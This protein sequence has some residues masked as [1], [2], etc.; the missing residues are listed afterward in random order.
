MLFHRGGKEK[1]GKEKGERTGER[2]GKDGGKGIGRG[3]S[4]L[5]EL[6]LTTRHVTGCCIKLHQEING[7]LTE[8]K[9]FVMVPVIGLQNILKPFQN[10]L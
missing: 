8:I 5:F 10:W 2:R 6:S 3:E 7:F 4:P 9:G 1:G